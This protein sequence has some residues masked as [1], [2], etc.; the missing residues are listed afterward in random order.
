[1]PYC[2]ENVRVCRNSDRHIILPEFL[3]TLLLWP[4]GECRF[5]LLFLS[6]DKVFPPFRLP[7][8]DSRFAAAR[9]LA[10]SPGADWHGLCTSTD[11]VRIPHVSVQCFIVWCNPLTQF[12]LWL[13]YLIG[14][15]IR[16]ETRAYYRLFGG[17]S[18][19]L[20]LPWID[21][22]IERKHVRI[23]LIW[24]PFSVRNSYWQNT[25]NNW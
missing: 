20:P 9:R 17:I 10:V 12:E 2:R 15:R 8:E 21:E 6:G 25:V 5:I 4:V 19:V 23:E 7:I 24:S 22:R 11:C 14:T 3:R 13:F 18:R 1:M 16:T